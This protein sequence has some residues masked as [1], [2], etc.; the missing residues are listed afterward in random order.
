MSRV[1]QTLEAAPGILA[2][3][4]TKARWQNLVQSQQRAIQILQSRLEGVREIKDGMGLHAPHLEELAARKLR[5]DEP[6][7]AREWDDVQ[8]A[9]RAH[10]LLTQAVELHGTLMLGSGSR[11]MPARGRRQVLRHD[12]ATWGRRF[13]SP[14]IRDAR[15]PY[16]NFAAAGTKAAYRFLFPT[17]MS[18]SGL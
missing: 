16:T 8:L 9:Q 17:S 14:C 4:S 1:Q 5:N 6:E 3:P 2:L 11:E 10:H 15:I 7:L 13:Y 12:Q 18:V